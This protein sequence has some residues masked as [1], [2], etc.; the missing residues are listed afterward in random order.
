MSESGRR[1]LTVQQGQ[2]IPSPQVTPATIQETMRTVALLQDMVAHI[3]IK[4]VDY[5]RIPGTPQDSL[6]DPGASQIIG[7]FN[8]Y[9]G[10]RR[11]L[12]LEDT[13]EKI[14]VCVEVPVISRQTQQE[15]GSGIGA[16]STQETKYKYRWV[17]DPRKWGFD[18]AT[19]KKLKTKPGRGDKGE[20]GTVY[21]IPNPEH[22]ELVNTIIKMASKRAEV[23]AAEGL[24]GVGSVLRQMFQGQPFKAE[25]GQGKGQIDYNAPRWQRFWGEVARLGYTDSQAHA[26]LQ[27][28]SMHDWLGQG[29]SLEEALIILRES[30]TSEGIEESPGQEPEAIE[31]T[32]EHD[33]GAHGAEI[34]DDAAFEDLGKGLRSPQPTRDPESIKDMTELYRACF[35]DFGM[36]PADVAKELGFSS[37]QAIDKTPTDCYQTIKAV[38]A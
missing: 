35:D 7:S 18:E 17:D 20:Y 32:I 4:G 3:L 10:Q 14:V 29:H 13:D 24:P 25:K 2:I 9:C 36:Q 30:E 5:G 6:W 31:G 15:V 38:R 28:K 11:I 16:A 12:K 19:I 37:T 27:V 26:K 23:D 1:D 22:S 34:S 8:C 33:P 21:R